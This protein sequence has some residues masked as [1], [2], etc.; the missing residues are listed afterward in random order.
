MS[1]KIEISAKELKAL[2]E[3]AA[4]EERRKE[5]ARK[6]S[7][8]HSEKRKAEG[9]MRVTVESAIHSVKRHRD[10][11]DVVVGLVWCPKDEFEDYK[12]QQKCIFVDVQRYTSSN[13]ERDWQTVHI[14]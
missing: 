10:A 6:A 11:G 12:R 9:I 14:K 4:R 13:N 3:A 1:D 5:A 7:A 8:K 2:R